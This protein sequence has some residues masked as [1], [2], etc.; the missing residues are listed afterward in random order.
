[1][2]TWDADAFRAMAHV[3]VFFFG[4]LLLFFTYRIFRLYS[5]HNEDDS[6]TNSRKVSNIRTAARP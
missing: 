1:M 4:F 3:Y 6:L 2:E 5:N